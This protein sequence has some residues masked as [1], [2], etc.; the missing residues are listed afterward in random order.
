MWEKV[1]DACRATLFRL[2]R[3]LEDGYETLLL[4]EGAGDR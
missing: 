1:E 4:G 3:V 2:V